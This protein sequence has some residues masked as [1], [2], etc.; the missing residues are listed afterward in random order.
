M[1]AIGET[2]DAEAPLD[3]GEMLVIEAEE[4]EA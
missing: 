3:L 4:S 1:I 2:G